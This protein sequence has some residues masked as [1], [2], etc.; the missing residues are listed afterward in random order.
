MIDRQALAEAG[1]TSDDA[2]TTW[3]VK[4]PKTGAT[5]QCR[6]CGDILPPIFTRKMEMDGRQLVLSLDASEADTVSKLAD[7]FDFFYH[8]KNSTCSP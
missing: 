2:G 3:T 5:L 7:F 8:S 1:F 4:L 6:T